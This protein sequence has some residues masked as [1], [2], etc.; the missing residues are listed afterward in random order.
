MARI[1]LLILLFIPATSAL[2]LS[3]PDP[4]AGFRWEPIAALTDEFD[5]TRLDAN[6]WYDHN[7]SW[8]GRPP[9][10]FMP[11]S[12]DVKDGHL[13]IRCSPLRAADG[14]FTIASGTIQ[15]KQKTLFGYYEC[16]MKAS[17][18]SASSNFWFVGEPVQTPR[19]KMGHELIVQFTI[20][21][22]QQ[23]NQFMKS[24]AMVSLKAPGADTKREKAK[25]T[26]RTKLDS[27]VAEDFHT[28]GCWWVD[29]NTLKFYVDGAYAYTLHP[30]K[31]FGDE[32]FRYPLALTLV[33]ETF[34]W[35]PTPTVE[36]LMDESRNTAMFDYVHSYR[37]VKDE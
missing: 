6:K 13:R 35:Q 30:S 21:K 22:S 3:P 8:I 19:G 10:K 34:D 9:G 2:A 33:C 32:P 25:V 1:P 5:G 20:G 31:K 27:S 14:K 12:I 23:H 29:A 18:L 7:P 36:E 17:R 15:A 11:S 4:P 37:L 26:D 28:Y 16:R 24:N